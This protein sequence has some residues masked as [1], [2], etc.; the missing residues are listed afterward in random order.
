MKVISN[1]KDYYDHQ[2]AKFGIDTIVNYE[3][4]CYHLDR[5]KWEKRGVYKPGHL[6]FTGPESYN[7]FFSYMIAFCGKI[8]TVGMYNRRAYFGE[9]VLKEIPVSSK[10][11]TMDNSR[12]SVAKSEYKWHSTETDLNN[13]HDCPVLLVRKVAGSDTLQAYIKNPRLADYGFQKV[14]S[15]EYAWTCINDFLINKPEIA[16][17]Q[18]DKEK[19]HSHGFDLKHSFRN[20]K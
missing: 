4:I 6:S 2:V 7:R 1:F 16:N 18:T 13:L 3:R 5:D 12:Y 17:N 20:I 15:P 10:W 8:Y 11:G 14:V 9:D 19:I